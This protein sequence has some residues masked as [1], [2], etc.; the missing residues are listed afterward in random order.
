MTE[1]EF[2][3]HVASVSMDLLVGEG[4]TL[5]R[6]PRPNEMH[7]GAPYAWIA[8]RVSVN[9]K[10]GRRK[11]S[12][13]S[14]ED[15]RRSGAAPRLRAPTH[16][17]A[18]IGSLL[19]FRVDGIERVSDFFPS[20]PLLA[21]RVSDKILDEA[22]RSSASARRGAELADHLPGPPS[23]APRLTSS[24]LVCVVT[25]KRDHRFGSNPFRR[26][27]IVLCRGYVAAFQGFDGLSETV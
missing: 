25:S 19:S 17:D 16:P 8:R 10:A 27:N 24:D 3:E 4:S 7:G 26:G 18:E 14:N 23:A 21:D 11:R 5:A 12:A 9:L 15:R 1:I 20:R 6:V 22:G 2:P 13:V